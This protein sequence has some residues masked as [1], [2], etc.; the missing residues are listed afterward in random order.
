MGPRRRPPTLACYLEALV[1]MR[2]V[3]ELHCDTIVRG[4]LT[5]VGDGLDLQL[6]SASI[7]P[8]QGPTRAAEYLYLRGSRVRYV[9]TPPNLHP[10]E[11]ITAAAKRRTS[12]L[13]A[14]AAQQG[15][16]TPAMPKGGH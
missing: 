14:H 4:V 2:L 1:G 9:H 5:A 13:A 3:I 7:A 11:A 16:H 10:R 6:E 8:L 15:K 12:A